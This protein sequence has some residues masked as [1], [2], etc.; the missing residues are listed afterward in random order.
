[1]DDADRLFKRVCPKCGHCFEATDIAM[2]EVSMQT[3][4]CEGSKDR[5]KGKLA[6]SL[7]SKEGK[8]N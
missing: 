5:D 4:K 3:H 2:L 6:N 7:I 8:Q 1:M